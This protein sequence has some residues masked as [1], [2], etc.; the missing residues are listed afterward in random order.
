MEIRISKI[1]RTITVDLA[2]FGL[3]ESTL[4]TN[5]A[6][7][8]RYGLTQSLNDAHAA[9]K[10]DKPDEVMAMVEK[11][12]TAI[13]SGITERA[14]GAPRDPLA[15]MM[16]RIARD[17]IRTALHKAGRKLST[18]EPADMARAV[19]KHT[20]ANEARIRAAAEKALAEAA[21][22]AEG[23]AIDDLFA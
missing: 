20:A 16:S 8:V 6:Y 23:V 12:L 11:K 10:A 21:A 4:A 2:K 14:V 15:A 7:V 19:A 9:I 3:D 17:E 13:V 5:A 18:I 22:T 1:D